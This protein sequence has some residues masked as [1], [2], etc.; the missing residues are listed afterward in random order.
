MEASEITEDDFN[1][2]EEEVQKLTNDF[3]KQIDDIVKE[4]EKEIMAV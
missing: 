3:T 4:K 2:L 1:D